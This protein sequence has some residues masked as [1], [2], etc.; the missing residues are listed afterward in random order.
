VVAAG[1]IGSVTLTTV[2]ADN[3][4]WKFGLL[5]DTAIGHL[6]VGSPALSLINITSDPSPPGTFGDFEVHVL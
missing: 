1:G 5:V 2:V 4:G 6:T 3:G